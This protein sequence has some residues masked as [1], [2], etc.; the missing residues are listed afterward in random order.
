MKKTK[1][2]LSLALSVC[3]LAASG[4]VLAVP[5]NQTGSEETVL[6][7]GDPALIPTEE[8]LEDIIND[9]F[10][11]LA[12]KS[13]AELRALLADMGYT[14]TDGASDKLD[15]SATAEKGLFIKRNGVANGDLKF[16]REI[17]DG[18]GIAKADTLLPGHNMKGG[19]KYY[20]D[21]TFSY[22]RTAIYINGCGNWKN[23][24]CRT[25]INKDYPTELTVY[26]AAGKY[27]MKDQNETVHVQTVVDTKAGNATGSTA[28][29]VS[30]VFV[31]DQHIAVNADN[32]YDYNGAAYYATFLQLM[33]FTLQGGNKAVDGGG[34]Y[35]KNFR[36]SKV[37]DAQP[38]TDQEKADA[39]QAALS[40]GDISAVTEN[41]TL[42]TIGSINGSTITWESANEGVIRIDG[43]TGVVTR[44]QSDTTVTL[45]ATITN[46]TATAVQTFSVTVKG[47]GQ[48]GQGFEEIPVMTSKKPFGKT[49]AELKEDGFTFDWSSTFSSNVTP[50]DDAVEFR[51][52]TG[53]DWI[54]KNTKD[55]EFN[56]DQLYVFRCEVEQNGAEILIQGIDAENKA[57]DN[58]ETFELIWKEDG[59]ILANQNEAYKMTGLQNQKVAFTITVNPR[60]KT[61][62]VS[63]ND[64]A[65]TLHDIP[66]Y[67]SSKMETQS[68][69]FFMWGKTPASG[70]IKLYDASVSRIET[71][72][73][74]VAMDKEAMD[75]GDIS[76]VTGDLNLPSSG[77]KGSAVSW[78][79]GNNA[80]IKIQGGTA[81]VTRPE[82][83]T[84]VILTATIAYGRAS[85]TRSFSVTVKGTGVHVDT[86]EEKVDADL[87]ALDLANKDN[88]TENFTLPAAGSVKGCAIEWKSNNEAVIR[89]SGNTAAV[90]RP[91]Q[92]TQVKLTATVRSGAVAKSKDITVTVKAKEQ[93]VIEIGKNLAL[94][95]TV[96]GSAEA[97][98]D[99][100]G[101]AKV[102]DGDVSSRLATKD[103][104]DLSN[105]WIQIDLGK[106]YRFDQLKLTEFNKRLKR[107]K[108]QYSSDGQSWT[109]IETY[110]LD[111]NNEN[112][113]FVHEPYQFTPVEGRYIRIY[114]LENAKNPSSGGFVGVSIYEAELYYT[115]DYLVSYDPNAA[116]GEE[117]YISGT[118]AAAMAKYGIAC[119]STPTD[120]YGGGIT[121][122]GSTIPGFQNRKSIVFNT[123][124]GALKTE[125]PLEGGRF[126][127]ANDTA[128]KPPAMDQMEN[129]Y[130][131]EMEFGSFLRNGQNAKKDSYWEYQFKGLDQNGQEV[132]IAVL[133][134]RL[135]AGAPEQNGML[136][137][138][139]E[140]VGADNENVIQLP[141]RTKAGDF[142][143]THLSFVRLY[144]D[145]EKQTYT[146]WLVKR[147]DMTAAYTE[148]EPG[149]ADLLVK[150]QPFDTA[151]TQLLGVDVYSA[152]CFNDPSYTTL[153]RVREMDGEAVVNSAK[154]ALEAAD[155]IGDNASAQQITSALELPEVYQSADVRWSV[156][157]AGVLGEDGGIIAAP[158]QDTEITLTAVLS[159]GGASASKELKV[160]VSPDAVPETD[161]R[162][163]E[164]D[165]EALTLGDV[166]AVI[167]NLN[168][169]TVGPK[170]GSAVSWNSSDPSVIET[171]GTVHRPLRDAEVT[172][173][174]AIS[175][176]EAKQTKTFVVTVKGT[177][178]SRTIA[179]IEGSYFSGGTFYETDAVNFA[180][181][182]E[183][184]GANGTNGT[185]YVEPSTDP[186]AAEINKL[187]G[188]VAE[189]TAEGIR[190]YARVHNAANP[191]RGLPIYEKTY[192][193]PE[194]TDPSTPYYL[195]VSFKMKAQG[196]LTFDFGQGEG[197]EAAVGSK[198]VMQVRKRDG[199]VAQSGVSYA[200]TPEG[201]ALYDFRTNDVSRATASYAD[202]EDASL[203]IYVIPELKEMVFYKNGQRVADKIFTYDDP[204][205]ALSTLH[206]TWNQE[207]R[208]YGISSGDY[209]ILKDI[210]LYQGPDIPAAERLRLDAEALTLSSISDEKAG[211]ITK[212]LNLYTTG[213]FGSSIVWSSDN[214]AVIDPAAGTV[215]RAAQEETVTLTAVISYGGE[216]REQTFV[217]T[218]PKK[219]TDGNMA[220]GGKVTMEGTSSIE[221]IANLT[222]G[223]FETYIETLDQGKKPKITIDLGGEKQF[224]KVVIYEGMADGRY[225]I[226]SGVLE[227]SS[228]KLTWTKVAETE[229]V[230]ANRVLDFVPVEARYIRF[231]VT[232]LAKDQVVRLYEI[233]AV[234][235]AS[236]A[237][238]VKADM[239]GLKAFDTYN[240]TE[241]TTFV[242]KG[243][244]G[245]DI[246]WESQNTSLVDSTGKVSRPAGDGEKVTITAYVSFGAVTEPVTF[247]HFIT[248]TGGGEP[249]PTRKPAGGGGGGGGSV[250]G[251]G[252]LVNVTDS[253]APTQKPTDGPNDN[254][255]VFE[256]VSTDSWAYPYIKSLYDEKILTGD[257][258]FEPARPILREEYLK[259]LL[260]AMDIA[261]EPAQESVFADVRPDDWFAGYVNTAH[262]LGLVNGMP[263]GTFGIGQEITRQDMAVLAKRAADLKGIVLEQKEARQL[264]DM[265]QV[266][267]YAK[268]SVQA[269]ADAAIISGD[270]NGAFNPMGSALREQVAKI[271]CLLRDAR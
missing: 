31:N 269:L 88:V 166:S 271:I 195:E 127:F 202:H 164:I 192:Q 145:L 153:L 232:G 188:L 109:D 141:L 265:E 13:D 170:R 47:T 233:E 125:D 210:K 72:A 51:R 144:V 200:G 217:L 26:G 99:Q 118:D 60:A 198:G 44:L 69:R 30:N 256:D 238:V 42:P 263:D 231:S 219:G 174:A 152:N 149:K 244:F 83:D 248:G 82:D 119:E 181:L 14:I 9:D 93:A 35:L 154:N 104:V 268:E 67:K 7:A 213:K 116:Q 171:D 96:S 236:D 142:K 221:D 98:S 74:K 48:S 206:I 57:N 258:Y 241:S 25:Q 121:D 215:T 124:N 240:V 180:D 18:A 167:E 53:S 29:C 131:L 222:D 262:Q 6:A 75:L 21:Y 105:Q 143:V 226:Q 49:E 204:A 27:K 46:G 157:P 38:E 59:T 61:Y 80:V 218:V 50:T 208:Y 103:W 92:D 173:T 183:G 189:K 151:I 177:Q 150:D 58:K 3:M 186:D 139:A 70:S 156:S 230:G 78:S 8:Q 76:A 235:D 169:A 264:A 16:S 227:V 32:R 115:G 89:V 77:A 11:T 134:T 62:D 260:L 73:D 128:N 85:D 249:T 196:A 155:V 97:Y 108:L 54:A 140:I 65:Q 40:L 86:D 239:R 187:P 1:R 161:A 165:T 237:A 2:I 162:K 94:K 185:V 203:G 252:G 33:D 228:D 135:P 110:S 243:K 209:L 28:Q 197:G 254:D 87:A 223:I 179:G 55:T 211:Q 214:P 20:V 4:S 113:T 129:G 68:L 101:Y 15:F 251:G 107:F 122:F 270:E 160:T 242:T 175:K 10:T 45:T 117:G 24:F 126:A 22:D 148:A 266:S 5:E 137:G 199:N 194:M 234:M 257:G 190:Y 168:L 163:V 205:T 84:D 146:A 114:I 64:G 184:D 112:G 261:A 37:S 250:S 52:G 159:R 23:V 253:P 95:K 225:A 130:M 36:V 106:T 220:T 81:A 176:G 229:T 41:L 246:R 136:M 178:P 158:Q 255:S 79:S 133:R 71:D 17:S 120:R 56:P 224:S 259:F 90:T 193:L 34:L 147:G 138:V 182:F 216:S 212:D 91:G 132:T 100:Y 12:G 172:L 43:G 267:G 19:G 66:F 247:N 245:S 63:V 111:A 191:G 39:D 102:T 207:I 123:R 201:P